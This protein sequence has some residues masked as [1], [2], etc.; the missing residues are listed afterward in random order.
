LEF[1]GPADVP[2][3]RYGF[4]TGN[5]TH[6]LEDGFSHAFRSAD[7]HQVKTLLNWVDWVDGPY[8]EARAGFQHLYPR[9]WASP[10]APGVTSD[11]SSTRERSRFQSRRRRESR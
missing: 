2:L 5:A 1:R 8:A 4:H 11:S 10:F 6:A 7:E 3:Q 9:R